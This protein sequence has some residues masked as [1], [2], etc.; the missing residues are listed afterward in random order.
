MDERRVTFES[1]F[2]TRRFGSSLQLFQV[3]HEV[4]LLRGGEAQ[5][6]DIVVMLDD[7]TQRWKTPVVVKTALGTG[8]QAPQRRRAV[9]SV[10]RTGRLEVVD[11]DFLASMHGPA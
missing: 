10:G 1:P 4:V 6:Q 3:L 8:E 9:F 2:R 11:A 5:L 7:V